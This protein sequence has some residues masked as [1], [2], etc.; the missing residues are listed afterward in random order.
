MVLWNSILKSRCITQRI[1]QSQHRSGTERNTLVILRGVENFYFITPFSFPSC[2][3]MLFLKVNFAGNQNSL[4]SSCSEV[5]RSRKPCEKVLKYF[6]LNF[7]LD[8]AFAT[9]QQRDMR[10]KRLTGTGITSDT[11]LIYSYFSC[12]E[13]NKNRLMRSYICFC[14]YGFFVYM[15]VRAPEQLLKAWT[16]FF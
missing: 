15:C 14:V 11:L 13:R 7:S 16:D 2:L 12:F 10:E 8:Q 3:L 9:C 1:C 6:I 4:K 5:Q